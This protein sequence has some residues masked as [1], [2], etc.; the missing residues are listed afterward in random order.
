M[1]KQILITW[2]KMFVIVIAINFLTSLFFKEFEIKHIWTYI[3][4]TLIFAIVVEVIKNI[5]SSKK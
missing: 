3:L 2:I 4:G 1:I 5:Q